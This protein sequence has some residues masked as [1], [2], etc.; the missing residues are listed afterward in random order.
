MMEKK[1][2]KDYVIRKSTAGWEVF[3][4]KT[5]QTIKLFSNALKAQMTKSHLNRG[6]GFA[7]DTPSF[8][9]KEIEKKRA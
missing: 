2:T 1:M 9:L 7:G 5:S 3:E 4:T 8:F 6:G